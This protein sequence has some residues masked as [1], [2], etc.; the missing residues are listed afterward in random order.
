[1]LMSDKKINVD[2][3]HPA[4]IN[5]LNFY[6]SWLVGISE[7]KQKSRVC[8]II[9]SLTVYVHT[10]WLLCV[11]LNATLINGI[12]KKTWMTR[13]STKKESAFACDERQWMVNEQRRMPYLYKLLS[14]TVDK[15]ETFYL[16][17]R[18]WWNKSRKKYANVT[19]IVNRVLSEFLLSF[20]KLISFN[21]R[22]IIFVILT[23]YFI[24]NILNFL[25]WKP[26][27]C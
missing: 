2:I 16:L 15:R 4:R 3:W 8:N 11:C 27:F 25:C 10:A 21:K 1:M 22:K 26:L 6:F 9:S 19:T 18:R 12:N 14:G 24:F 23:E 17:G 20:F 7:Q 13:Y 5:A